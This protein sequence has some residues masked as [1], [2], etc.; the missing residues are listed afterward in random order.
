MNVARRLV[1]RYTRPVGLGLVLAGLMVSAYIFLV[2]A[3]QVQTF[4]FDAYAYWSVSMPDPYAVPIGGLGSFNYTPPV[5]LVF[6][7]FDT[8]EW[9]V[10]LWLWTALLVGSVIWIGWSPMG[11][12]I[13]FAVP[14]VALEIYHGNIHILLAVAMVLGFRHPWAWTAVLLTKPT[15]AVGLAWFVVRGQWRDRAVA[16]APAAVIVGLTLVLWPDLWVGWSEYVRAS[17]DQPKGR[18]AVDVSLWL[19]L[20]A[21]LAVVAWGALTDRRWAVVAG[22]TLALPVLWLASLAMLAGVIP[23]WRRRRSVAEL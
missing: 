1:R 11:I 23:E 6:D 15:A 4:G 14:F 22:S 7:R 9:W 2:A 12:A 17:L 3:P 10:F 18:T 20:P 21:G 5:A 19:R 13:A 16:V 8:L